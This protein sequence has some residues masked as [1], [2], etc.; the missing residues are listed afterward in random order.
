MNKPNKNSFLAIA[1][2]LAPS[3]MNSSFAQEARP[4]LVNMKEVPSSQLLKKQRQNKPLALSTVKRGTNASLQSTKQSK[5]Q[6]LI[7]SVLP[8]ARFSAK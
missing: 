5:G 3:L 1:L 4:T 2:F 8:N 6:Y 7:H